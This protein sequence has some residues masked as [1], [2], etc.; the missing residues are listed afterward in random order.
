MVPVARKTIPGLEIMFLPI[1]L[2][3]TPAK[4][5]FD[6]ALRLHTTRTDSLEHE[7]PCSILPMV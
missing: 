6:L 5:G 1:V 4:K 7:G 2:H 3:Y